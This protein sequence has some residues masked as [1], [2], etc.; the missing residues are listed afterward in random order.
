M[1]I[2]VLDGGLAQPP[3]YDV[4]QYPEQ[5]FD[6]TTIGGLV[7]AV[8]KIGLPLSNEARDYY[9]KN[10]ESMSGQT[11]F[12]TAIFNQQGEEIASISYIMRRGQFHAKPNGRGRIWGADAVKSTQPRDISHLIRG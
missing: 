2:Q 11:L 3:V 9:V 7:D 8:Q 4:P 5:G 6:C 12:S 1:T 10:P